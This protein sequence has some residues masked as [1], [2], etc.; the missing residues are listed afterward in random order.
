MSA[1]PFLF[2]LSSPPVIFF[3]V[4]GLL[5]GDVVI[6]GRSDELSMLLGPAYL[7]Y[8]CTGQSGCFGGRLEEACLSIH[9]ALVDVAKGVAVGEFELVTWAALIVDSYLRFS[10]EVV[11]FF[12]SLELRGE[13]ASK[14]DDA[15]Q[16][17]PHAYSNAP[18][19]GFDCGFPL[20][21]H[22]GNTVP[23]LP[24]VFTGHGVSLGSGKEVFKV[25]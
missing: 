10:G 15:L 2:S 5:S 8:V 3:R 12:T 24:D 7:G 16:C 6:N 13:A 9:R 1:A 11:V 19:W 20:F 21:R 17:R 18:L 23:T 25:S 14:I 4:V 22:Q